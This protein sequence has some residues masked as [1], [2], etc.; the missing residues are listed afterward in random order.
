MQKPYTKTRKD[1]NQSKCSHKNKCYISTIWWIL[2]FS[3]QKQLKKFK[4]GKHIPSH[5]EEEIQMGN[6]KGYKLQKY[7]LKTSFLLFPD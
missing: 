2:S 4:V 3:S 6:I 7:K 1:K 5:V